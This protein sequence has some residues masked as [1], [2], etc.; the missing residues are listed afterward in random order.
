MSSNNSNYLCAKIIKT[1]SVVVVKDDY[2]KRFSASKLTKQRV[3][4]GRVVW[5]SWRIEST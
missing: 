3:V 5:E 1:K 4:C 2:T